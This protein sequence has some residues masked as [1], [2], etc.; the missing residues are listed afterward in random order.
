MNI[1]HT[2]LSDGS[3]WENAPQVEEN[4]SSGSI[5]GVYVPPGKRVSWII[6]TKNNGKKF[7]AG[8]EFLDIIDIK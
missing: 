7:V 3:I 2:S 4:P 8:Y 5:Q 1:S 6:V